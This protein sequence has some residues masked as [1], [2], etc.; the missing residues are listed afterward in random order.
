MILLSLFKH[1]DLNLRFRVLLS[2]VFSPSKE[3]TTGWSIHNSE[4]EHYYCFF[5]SEYILIFDA[6]LR[7]GR[8]I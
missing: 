8:Y 1:V 3:F 5:F 4:Q 7:D 2:T 6:F